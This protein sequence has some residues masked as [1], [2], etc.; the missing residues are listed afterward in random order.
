MKHTTNHGNKGDLKT[1]EIRDKRSKKREAFSICAKRRR[2]S[3][4]LVQELCNP[5][6]KSSSESHSSNVDCTQTTPKR[7]SST[8]IV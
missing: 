7:F 4:S 3:A 6:R 2:V 1:K 8:A 5:M